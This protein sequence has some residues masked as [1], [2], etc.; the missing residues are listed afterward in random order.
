ME[1]DLNQTI[2]K[3]IFIVNNNYLILTTVTKCL[4]SKYRFL[5]RKYFY[6]FFSVIGSKFVTTA[7]STKNL[8]LK[9]INEL[10]MVKVPI[11][12]LLHTTQ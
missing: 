3:F 10:S 5:G 9:F 1:T 7:N 8:K 11:T 4:G 12:T 2:N 6:L